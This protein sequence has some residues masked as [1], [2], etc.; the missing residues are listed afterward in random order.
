MNTG[1]RRAEMVATAS[2]FGV[3]LACG[4]I[5]FHEFNA[6]PEVNG[7]A[8]GIEV[9]A[10]GLKVACCMFGIVEMCMVFC[11]CCISGACKFYG[12]IQYVSVATSIHGSVSRCLHTTKLTWL[13]ASAKKRLVSISEKAQVCAYHE[14]VEN[15]R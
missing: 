7:G 4:L 9:G 2:K 1:A 5:V 11:I 15:H 14:S 13:R 3:G 8:A 12:H 6:G 10:I